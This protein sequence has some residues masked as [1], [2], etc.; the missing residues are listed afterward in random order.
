MPDK[1][2]NDPARKCP[3]CGADVMNQVTALP[4]DQPPYELERV[5]GSIC[6]K[7]CGWEEL[8]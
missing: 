6:V 7:Y 1:F 2:R 4:L 5:V 3:D 8:A